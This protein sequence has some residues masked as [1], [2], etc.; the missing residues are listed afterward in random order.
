[1]SVLSPLYL[2]DEPNDADL[3]PH[4]GNLAIPYPLVCGDINF[5][6]YWQDG[7]IVWIWGERKK[8][9][10]MVNC[11]LDT[12]RF[13]R[14]IQDARQAGFRFFFLILEGIFRRG[15]NGLLEIRKGN[16]WQ[17]YHV[18]PRN[19]QS[20]TVPYYRISN[21]LNQCRYYLGIHVYRTNS[22]RETAME[23]SDL[24][25]MFQQPPEAHS[26]LKQFTS[27]SGNDTVTA[28]L[29]KPSLI[30]RLAK[31]LP[32]I[33][34]DRSHGFERELGSAREMCRILADNDTK[35]LLKIE[36]IGKK[37][38]ADILAEVNKDGNIR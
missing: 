8:L 27:E 38:A 30:R 36:G 2:T 10:D 25:S 4:L 37:I 24:Y 22:P 5:Q 13:L 29:A 21:Y 12:G 32:H 26:S 19:P 17:P 15:S 33:G 18:D 16:D 34:W 28:Y 6:G 1:V 14:Q 9:S 11:A 7:E 31:E 35:R 20:P 23:I 3:I